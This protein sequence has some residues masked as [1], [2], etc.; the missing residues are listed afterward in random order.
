MQN[1]GRTSGLR[2][3]DHSTLANSSN[4]NR[5]GNKKKAYQLRVGGGPS[6]DPSNFAVMANQVSAVKGSFGCR[7]AG[8]N[9]NI[10]R[11]DWR[12]ARTCGAVGTEGFVRGWVCF[13]GNCKQL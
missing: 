11:G 2:I 5:F 9:G 3:S 8:R 4:S 12:S 1:G 6:I 10:E 7:L 13:T